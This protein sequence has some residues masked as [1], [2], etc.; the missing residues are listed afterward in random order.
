MP[1]RRRRMSGETLPVLAHRRLACCSLT[2]YPPPRLRE[3]RIVCDSCAMLYAAKDERIFDAARAVNDL[4]DVEGCGTGGPLHIVVDDTNVEDVHLDA[5]WNWAL[6]PSWTDEARRATEVAL[7]KLRP[8]TLLER[9]IVSVWHEE[10]V[11][12]DEMRKAG[13][14]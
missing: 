12:R 10:I 6:Q 11:D 13:L 7:T 1:A 9:A 14:E 3:G 2:V 8:L 5:A 4:Y